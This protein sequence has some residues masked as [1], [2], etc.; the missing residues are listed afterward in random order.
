MEPKIFQVIVLFAAF[1]GIFLAGYIFHKKR[2]RERFVC[3]VG[4]EC[5]AVVWSEYSTFFGI[6]LE[7]LGIIYYS[8]VAVAYGIFLALPSLA[9]PQLVF[10]IF[11]ASVFAFLFSIYL[12]FIQAFALKEWCSWCLASAGLCTV[13]FAAA[14]SGSGYNFVEL[15]EH[16][17]EF[18]LG[19]HVLGMALGLGGATITDVLFFRFLKDF[20]ISEKENE[21]FRILSQVLWF[22]I[23]V[24][25]LSGIGIFL[26]DSE[27]LLNSPKFLVK[28]IVVVVIVVNGAILN[29]LV[30]P[31]MVKICFGGEHNHEKGELHHLRRLAYALGAISIISWYSAFILG[32]LVTSP[33]PF[34]PLLGIYVFL[35]ILGVLGSQIMDRLVGGK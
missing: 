22:A 23:L 18:L 25:I 21:V 7:I 9:P 10:G 34:L 15:L 20:R 29:I 30:A 32:S 24:V 2:K 8:A 5:Q 31:H 13:I 17:R 35:L 12:T 4:F 16:N 1:A 14:V 19:L 6:P 33:L 28:M 26:P 11:L 3:P 27:R